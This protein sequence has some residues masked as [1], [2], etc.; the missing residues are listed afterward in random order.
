LIFKNLY[1]RM[2]GKLIYYFDKIFA[3]KV[4]CKYNCLKMNR[5]S[6]YVEVNQ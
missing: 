2:L 6:I 5:I 1:Y 4:Y 3:T